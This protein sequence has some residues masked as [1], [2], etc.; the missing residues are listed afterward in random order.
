MYLV[1]DELLVVLQVHV[2]GRGTEGWHLEA[3]L[4]RPGLESK[5]RIQA[6]LE[7]DG[8]AISTSDA[9]CPEYDLVQAIA[10][11]D[12]G[13]PADVSPRD[14]P[15]EPGDARQESFQELNF[16]EETCCNEVDAV[17]FEEADDMCVARGHWQDPRAH[18]VAAT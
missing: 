7:A 18:T 9:K 17:C 6:M 14:C 1:I 11:P 16:F 15:W 2:E 8:L 5:A 10:T 12:V 3:L 13:G 4:F